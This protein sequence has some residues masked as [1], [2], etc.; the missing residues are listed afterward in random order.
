MRKDVLERQRLAEE[1]LQREEAEARRKD[2][3]ERRRGEKETKRRHE[4]EVRRQQHFKPYMPRIWPN[5]ND[6]Q[7]KKKTGFL[8]RLRSLRTMRKRAQDLGRD[9]SLYNGKIDDVFRDA[10][11]LHRVASAVDP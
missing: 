10:W 3:L 5:L 7:V 6:V 9:A 1:K 4:E 2:E 11:G 8:K